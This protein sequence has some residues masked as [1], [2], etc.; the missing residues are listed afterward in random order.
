MAPVSLKRI[1]TREMWAEKDQT[2]HIE[3]RCSGLRGGGCGVWWGRRR[4]DPG[5]GR[6]GVA[7]Y[8]LKKGMDCS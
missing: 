8:C 1:R 5:A 7:G 6:V 4:K 3:N 2:A